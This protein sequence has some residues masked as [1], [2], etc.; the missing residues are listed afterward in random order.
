MEPMSPV[1][2]IR[3]FF[4][5]DGGKKVAL[6]ELQVLKVEEREELG[7]LAA[8]ELGVELILKS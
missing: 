4:E 7:K 3:T 8:I 1:K 2:A 6:K 5:K